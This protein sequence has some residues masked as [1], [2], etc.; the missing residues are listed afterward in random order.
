MRVHKI[1]HVGIKLKNR[2]MGLFSN[3]NIYRDHK[4]FLTQSIK[5]KL[6]GSFLILILL[7]VMFGILAYSKASKAIINNHEEST[8]LSVDLIGQY[9]AQGLD[10]VETKATEIALEQKTVD[11]YSGKLKDDRFDEFNTYTEISNSI[12]AKASKDKFIYN[13]NI[14]GEYGNDITYMGVLP[15]DAEGP[16]LYSKFIDSL[17]IK[18]QTDTK[19][20]D[21]KKIGIWSGYH[22]A[23]DKELHISEDT[24]CMSLYRPLRNIANKQIG[25]VV[26]DVRMDFINDILDKANFGEGSVT[27]VITNDGR[28]IV[29]DN[30]ESGLLQQSFY[31]KAMTEEM[32]TGKESVVFNSEECLFIYS[33]LAVSNAMIY[34]IIPM[35][36]I[37]ELV[38]NLGFIITICALAACLIAVIIGTYLTTVISGSIH[39][40]NK[41]LEQA[42]TGDLSGELRINRKDEFRILAVCMNQ[43]LESIKELIRKMMSVSSTLSLSTEQV[44]RNSSVLLSATQDISK[45]V[46]DIEQG[47]Y[48]QAN[49]TQ[50]CLLQMNTLASQ[51]NTLTDNAASIDLITENAKEIINDGLT[52]VNAL[53]DKVK[54]TSA[55][56]GE[57]IEKIEGLNKDSKAISE[58]TDAINMIA[59]QTSLLSLNASIEAA[60]AG[61][62]GYG[63]GVVA[64]EIGKLAE[65]SLNAAKKI[66][67]II[68][69]IQKRTTDTMS[70]A[71]QV[72]ATVAQQVE[73]LVT[74]VNAFSGINSEVEKLAYNMKIMS[75][76]MKEMEQVKVETLLAM[77][78]ISA[79]S[80]ETAAATSE[81]GSTATNQ[82]NA[83]VALEQAARVLS[84][85]S[86]DM[87]QSVKIFKVK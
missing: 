81:L 63:F 45:T 8:M 71:N 9:L 65:Q 84:E 2:I 61:E 28:E 36:S 10:A 74:T 75:K 39:K 42:A 1:K 47:I 51:I 3:V 60:R 56:T 32:T 20:T 69:Q 34:T 54:S 26:I 31:K 58:I 33:K 80:E 23:L 15:S 49:D 78:S 70:T 18:K 12:K 79:I 87:E 4:I 83:V 41:V 22:T 17:E 48:Q 52:T 64:Q 73:A 85:D 14:F 24:Y 66:D 44:A 57:V 21:T 13:I 30:V 68:Q 35:S 7:I 37:T 38:R 27:G 25:Y 43:T 62:A 67:V 55:V 19:M 82:L 6:M 77:E 72:E 53:S 76:G 29:K 59:S 86:R 46:E 11:Y 5:F 40:A 16:Y 50:N